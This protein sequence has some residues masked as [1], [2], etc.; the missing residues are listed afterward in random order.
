M[1]RIAVQVQR[2][3]G[4]NEVIIRLDRVR[5]TGPQ[6]KGTRIEHEQAAQRVAADGAQTG[7]RGSDW[8][9]GQRARAGLNQRDH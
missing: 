9:N 5:E 4:R 6:L 2:A 3:A 1:L 8:R 7:N